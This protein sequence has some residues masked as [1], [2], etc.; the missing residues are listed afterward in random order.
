MRQKDRG[1]YRKTNRDVEWVDQPDSQVNKPDID[2][3]QPA[4]EETLLVQIE[5]LVPTRELTLCNS[6]IGDDGKR[7]RERKRS[8][9]PRVPT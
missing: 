6:A 3:G 2:V 8:S 4:S 9:V 5:V 7:E 1:R